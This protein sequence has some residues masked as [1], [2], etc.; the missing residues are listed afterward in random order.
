MIREYTGTGGAGE[1]LEKFKPYTDTGGNM[2]DVE[3][4]NNR[5]KELKE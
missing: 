2:D 1:V 3:K 5:M 4:F